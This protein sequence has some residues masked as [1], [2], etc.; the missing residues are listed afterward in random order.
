MLISPGFLWVFTADMN[1]NL[2]FTGFAYFYFLL[3]NK[4]GRCS[5]RDELEMWIMDFC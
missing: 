2:G 4:L 5:V 1:E 3:S